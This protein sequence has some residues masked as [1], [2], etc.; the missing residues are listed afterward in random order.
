MRIQYGVI[1]SSRYFNSFGPWATH[2]SLADGHLQLLDTGHVIILQRAFQCWNW[3]CFFMKTAE[4][5]A[6][7]SQ[8]CWITAKAEQKHRGNEFSV[9]CCC[10]ITCVCH[11]WEPWL[12]QIWTSSRIDY[13]L[14]ILECMVV[15]I[16]FRSHFWMCYFFY[17]GCCEHKCHKRLT[18][19]DAFWKIEID[20]QFKAVLG[21]LH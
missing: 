14:L 11:Y 15:I 17:H 21:A 3:R 12:Y 20:N 16:F 4:C 6:Q 2:I 13:F 19:A 5:Q 8:D 7:R 9:L 10:K 18:K 1:T